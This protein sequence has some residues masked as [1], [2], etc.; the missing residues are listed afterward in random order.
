MADATP[1]ADDTPIT[2]AAHLDLHHRIFASSVQKLTYNVH[3]SI[4]FRQIMLHMRKLVANGYGPYY[5]LIKSRVW[6]SFYDAERP[7]Q[8][9]MAI[10]YH[11]TC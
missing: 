10:A 11:L 7:L 6:T 2:G 8:L 1:G 5:C 4:C 3:N 9:E